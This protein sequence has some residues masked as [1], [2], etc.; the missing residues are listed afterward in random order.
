MISADTI[1]YLYLKGSK[2]YRGF[3]G[4]AIKMSSKDNASGI[5]QKVDFTKEVSRKDG[6]LSR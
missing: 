3:H 1:T 2:R 6:F 5:I 4:R